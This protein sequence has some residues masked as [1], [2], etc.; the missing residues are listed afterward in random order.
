MELFK[1]T[2]IEGCD[3]HANND[4][5]LNINNVVCFTGPLCMQQHHDIACYIGE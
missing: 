3:Q 1:T 5:M 4:Y 2:I